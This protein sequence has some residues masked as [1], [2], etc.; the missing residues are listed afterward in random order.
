[1]KRIPVLLA[2][3][4]LAASIFSQ[5]DLLTPELLWKMGRLGFEDVSPDGKTAVFG[6]QYFD[7][8]TNKSRRPIFSVPTG[9]GPTVQLTATDESS[10]GNAVFRPD[11]Q[12]IGFLRDGKFWEMNPDGSAPKQVNDLDMGGFKWS[13]DG[14]KIL[15]TQD[16]KME[17]TA[18]DQN[19]DLPKTSAKIIDGLMY[20]HWKSWSDGKY[21]NVFVADYED[22]KLRGE[23]RNIMNQPFD[24]PLAP[25]GGMEQINWSPDGRFILYT[26]K[27]LTGTAAATSTNSD[28]FAW[29]IS[30]G[31]TVNISEGLPGYDFDPIFSPDGRFLAWTNQA[32][33][34]YEADRTRLMVYDLS[35]S[36]REEL[37]EGWNFECNHP[38]W[39]PDGN[40]LVFLSSKE[41][42]YH[43]FQIDRATKK[44]R[45]VTDGVFNLESFKVVDNQTVIAQKVS[46]SHPA[47][48]ATISLKNGAVRELTDLNNG[49]WSKLKTGRVEKRFVK[50]T[51]GK[52]MLVW[53]ILPPDFDSRKKYPSIL[54]CQGGP[55]SP[56]AQSFSYR[57]NFQLMAANGYVVIA[58]VRRGCPGMG[59]EWTDEINGD[60]GG[61]AMQDLLSA[62]DEISKEPFIDNGKIGAAGA[63][64]GGYSVY[65][66]AGNHQ[67]R[68]KS[69]ISHCGMFNMESWY[70]QTEELF[71]ANHDLGGAYWSSKPGETWAK[72]S[73]HKY[74][75]NWDTPLLVIHN[76]KDFRVPIGEGFQAFQ[77]AQLRGIPSR[78]LYFDDEGHHM[79]KPQNSLLWQRTFFD[80]MDTYVKGTPKPKP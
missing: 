17:P 45:Q 69:F 2:S 18:A 53:L 78:L 55:Q 39:L 32:T 71:F 73:P 64:F 16:I 43:L 23:L 62:T 56:L 28:I 8:T 58:P 4:F 50:T 6:V 38:A 11:G 79:S 65:W 77:A 10:C 54:F 67:K 60:W 75:Q 7:A 14:K 13:P 26:C 30:S 29:E 35:T 37:T 27:K 48:I 12:K 46:M 9:G 1:M 20:R 24:S 22:G 21:S 40:S 68:F 25:F 42:A 15:F 33:P 57:W 41:S 5:T 59:Q 44:I 66:L 76:E 52:Q 63:S 51:D 61:L 19:P 72:D 74:V 34:G 47:E 80:W 3:L 36:Q 49:I 70:G 31:K